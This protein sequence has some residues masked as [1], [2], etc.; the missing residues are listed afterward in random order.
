M[1]VVDQVCPVHMRGVHISV[2]RRYVRMWRCRIADER[3]GCLRH[4]PRAHRY[5]ASDA[6]PERGRHLS[7]QH[8]L[9]LRWIKRQRRE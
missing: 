1:Y 3:C 5:S 6:S 2:H 7:H 9:A 4:P 8:L